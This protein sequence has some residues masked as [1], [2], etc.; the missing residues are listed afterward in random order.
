MHNSR[1]KPTA[2]LR[3]KNR[4]LRLAQESILAGVARSREPCY[5]VT[6]LQRRQAKPLQK[7]KLRRGF[8]ARIV[9]ARPITQTMGFL[10]AYLLM[11]NHHRTKAKF[12]KEV[13]SCP[14]ILT[15]CLLCHL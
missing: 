9:I 8:P 10:A 14:P 12:P 2:D 5:S 1:L 11:P 6:L 13:L 3:Y 15:S 4:A 7:A